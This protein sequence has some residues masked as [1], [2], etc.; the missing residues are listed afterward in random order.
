MLLLES[1]V[2]IQLVKQPL[3][4]C[5]SHNVEP[6]PIPAA[7]L[8]ILLTAIVAGKQRKRVQPLWALPFIWETFTEF[9]ASAWPSPYNGS[10][11]RNGPVDGRSGYLSFV[12]H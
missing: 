1:S 7:P 8:L 2:G 10:H 4:M 6:V 12:S 3:V 9:L 11:L 5:I